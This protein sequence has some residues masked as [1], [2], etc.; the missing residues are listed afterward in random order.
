MM[1]HHFAGAGLLETLGSA[2]MGLH[3]RHNSVL[4]CLGTGNIE[5][6]SG[7]K[8]NRRAPGTAQQAI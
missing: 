4:T 2:L 3:L 8:S 1:A 5:W 7:G 6:Q